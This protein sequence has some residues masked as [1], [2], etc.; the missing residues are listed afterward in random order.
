M[1][2]QGHSP[3]LIIYKGL[4]SLWL[5]PSQTLVS[6]RIAFSSQSQLTI[7]L[8]EVEWDVTRLADRVKNTQPQTNAEVAAED[9]KLAR[10][11]N[12]PE[13]GDLDEPATIVDKF[14]RI[15]VWYLSG[16]FHPSVLVSCLIPSVFL[17]K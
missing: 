16:I 7:A 3:P 5:V 15:I 14:G 4:S 10:F 2:L 8:D 1:S 9:I 13:F 11:F 12:N 17:K 6:V